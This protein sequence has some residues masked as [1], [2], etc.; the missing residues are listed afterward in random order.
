MA[1]HFERAEFDGRVSAAQSL[2][3][4]RKLDGLLIFRPES[5]YYLCGYDTFGYAM[6]QCLYL[7]ADGDGLY[8][9][10]IYTQT[11]ALDTQG[12]VA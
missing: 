3:A 12:H 7:G 6:F 1:L 9:R 8:G 11:F 4:E 5:M 10:G 2:L